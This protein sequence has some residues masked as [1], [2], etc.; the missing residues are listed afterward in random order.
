ML[1]VIPAVLYS[2]APASAATSPADDQ[3]GIFSAGS[4]AAHVGDL[5]V[6]LGSSTTIT[7]VTAHLVASGTAD[8]VLDPV[9]AE[10]AS[11][12]YGSSQTQSTWSVPAAITEGE[13]P[14]GVYSI[15]VDVT[16]ADQTTQSAQNIGTLSFLNEPQL[17][18]TADHTDVGYDYAPTINLT[19]TAAILAPDGTTTPYTGGTLALTTNFGTSQTLTTDASGDFTAQVSTQTGSWIDVT[20]AAASG[21]AEGTATVLLTQVI[22]PV[23]LSAKLS[24]DTIRYGSGA[25]ETVTGTLSYLPDDKGTAYK[26]LSGQPVY[27]YNPD[28]N[29]P[30]TPIA[31]GT[32]NADGDF[33]IKLPASVVAASVTWAVSAGQSVGDD[34][35]GPAST[36]LS[37]TVQIPTVITNFHVTLNQYWGL[38]FSGCLNQPK[39]SPS[40][41]I[42]PDADVAF[43]YSSGGKNGPWHTLV[44]NV[45]QSGMDCGKGGRWYAWTA[46]APQNYAYY[47]LS[48][49]GGKP[50]GGYAY[51][52]SASTPTLAWKYDDRITGL[53]VSPHVVASNGRLT[54]KGQLQYYYS[55]WR[56]YANQ[57]I[58]I[59]FRQKGSSTWYWIVK[60]KTNSSGHFSATFKDS[61]GSATWSAEFEGNSTHLAASPPGVY[62]RVS[63]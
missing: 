25:A 49:P 17:T 2:A 14:L 29:Y 1:G 3:F 11:A 54:V 34:L 5:T 50:A 27:I 4:P 47:R 33:S 36:T 8:D 9:L 16:F 7:A 62:V 45:P 41:Q 55:K 58:Y 32:T 56:D 35:F 53:S 13:L 44:K 61:V 43:Q 51:L 12:P 48:Y 19:G 24:A 30:S 38:S 23:K 10:T 21:Q 20:M 46:T 22:D 6:V 31:S 15:S 52:G 42:S 18:M 59:I 37:I 28:S 63:G 57:T 39:D 26:P 40:G 60:A